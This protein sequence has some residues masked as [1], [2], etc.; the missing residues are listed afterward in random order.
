MVAL[1]IRAR[2]A[3]G[4]FP[5]AS[6]DNVA[7]LRVEGSGTQWVTFGML[8]APGAVP[9]GQ[10][11]RVD[12]VES[13]GSVQSTWPED[14]S[15][16]HVMIPAQV[17]GG[18]SYNI[19]TVSPQG[20]NRTV[21]QLLANIA[22]DIASVSIT[23]G[24]TATVTARD[25]LESATNR[26]RLNN[27]SNYL[28]LEQSPQM[29]GVVVAR[30]V[31]THL[32]VTMHIRW[33]GGSTLW[34]NFVFELGYA[35]IAGKD[36]LSYTAVMNINGAQVGTQ[37]LTSPVHY[38]RAM[39]HKNFWSTGGTL[40]PRLTASELIDS[41]L[42]PK[43]G[44]SVPTNTY[45]NSVAQ[46]VAPMTNGDL[47]DNLGAGG[48]H[49]WLG[50]LPRWDAVYVT[51]DCDIRGY[52]YMLAEADAAMSYQHSVLM[53]SVTGESLSV[54]DR[55][56]AVVQNPSPAGI[57]AGWTT[58]MSPYGNNST[59]SGASHGLS[60]GFTA[61]AVTG[62]WG[63]LREMTHWTTS[64]ITWT[65]SNRNTTFNGMTVRRGYW[66]STRGVAWTYR[67]VAQAARLL[68]NV[69]YL[70][71]YFINTVDG[72]FSLDTNE[73]VDSPNFPLGTVDEENG[74][75][76]YK[77]FMHAFLV[78]SLGYVVLDL[79]FDSGLEFAQHTAT[80]IAGLMGN[81]GE[82]VWNFGPGEDR[83]VGV[84]DSGTRYTTFTQMSAD[85]DNVPSYAQGQVPGS[86][87]LANLM[88]ANGDAD[89]TL[90]GT[91]SGTPTSPTGYPANYR[92]AVSYLTRLG[93]SGGDACW[94]RI[95]GGLQADYSNIPQFNIVPRN[96]VVE[97][98]A[99]AFSMTLGTWY[100]I[101]GNSPGLSLSPTTAGTR[102]PSDVSP[103]GSSG[104]FRGTDGAS[105]M[106][107]TWNSTVGI[108][109]LG[110]CGSIGAYG[111]GHRNFYGNGFLVLDLFT[112]Q[113]RMVT[114]PSTA[115]PFSAGAL[116]SIGAYTDGTPSPPHNY[117][118]LVYIPWLRKV[119]VMKSIARINSPDS[120]SAE[121]LLPWMINVDTGTWTHGPEHPTLL[122]QTGGASVVDTT[123][124]GVWTYMFTGT[125]SIPGDFAFYGNIGTSNGDGTFGTFSDFSSTGTGQIDGALGY[126]PDEDVVLIFDF[127]AGL[128]WRKDPDNMT[129]TRVAVS[130]S[131]T[132]SLEG[133]SSITYSRELRGFVMQLNGSANVYLFQTSNGWTSGTWTAKTVNANGAVF[134]S[135]SLGCG[136]TNVGMYN[137]AHIFEYGDIVLLVNAPNHCGPAYAMRLA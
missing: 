52:R 8:F 111:G 64:M 58:G 102:F 63:Y 3:V 35:D 133:R 73:F 34:C 46:S 10:T 82:Y 55:P 123:R 24:A 42:I 18:Q 80:L 115:G 97:A 98:P 47:D 78:Q 84:T 16:L 113:W 13:E 94:S 112:R 119:A 31:N 108:P 50:L 114:Q 105:A 6:G 29:L 127:N 28:V 132:P 100:Q 26:A 68:P 59:G 48:A 66:G 101:T 76:E 11:V 79:G 54:N 41:F 22:G 32:R 40:Y 88:F 95:T 27:T 130:M 38:S 37:A 91:L 120:G 92:P 69:H 33:Y 71:P 15:A 36:Q 137:K 128:V 1:V 49:D 129:A 56:T 25:L 19:S 87:A 116:L 136:A 109:D 107:N 122:A 81:T 21:S 51:S 103:D 96:Q 131:G 124:E 62:M 104:T 85:L 53:D 5:Q 57:A 135:A 77:T 7:T 121:R 20:G 2:D 17:T 89:S 72:M 74:D 12:G 70:K 44:S 65:Q 67:N 75:T 23:G 61:Y 106:F 60:A 45:L 126:D 125:G 83:E 39:W 4:M 30:D 117:Y 134:A 9:A 90:I 93:I 99:Y 110:Q 86:Q 43:Y 118:H 14:G